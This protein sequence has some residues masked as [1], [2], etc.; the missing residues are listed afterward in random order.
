MS[1]PAG[2]RLALFDLDNTLL[3]GDTDVLWCGFLIACGR[4]DR[5]TFAAANADME[6]RYQAGNA[7]AAEFCAF[8]VS[9]LKGITRADGEVLRQQFFE[10]WIRPRISDDARAL[11]EKHRACGDVLI[12]TT[13]TNRFTTELTA[14]DLGI[15]H[16]IAIEIEE[17]DEVFTGNTLGVLNMREG[18]VVRLMEWLNGRDWDVS[19]LKDATFY[20]DSINDLPLLSAAAHPIAVDPDAK[21]APLAVEL[22]WTTIKL[23]RNG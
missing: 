1:A 16:L 7:T 23:R 6:K 20:S 8:Y 12:L 17:V 14:C 22:G 9:L 5:E 21:L 18:K 2:T 4:L 19:L 10:E 15:E 11:V 13:A 3:T